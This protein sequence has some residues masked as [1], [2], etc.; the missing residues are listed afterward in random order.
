MSI[1]LFSSLKRLKYSFST[2]NPKDGFYIKSNL[3]LY[4]TETSA[5]RKSSYR[6]LT[7]I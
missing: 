7:Y 6:I 2:Y 4:K 5:Q 3:K 1:I